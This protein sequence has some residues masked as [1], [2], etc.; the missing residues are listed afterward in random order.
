LRTS[1]VVALLESW[2]TARLSFADPLVAL[3]EFR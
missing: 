2:R 1:V 3:L